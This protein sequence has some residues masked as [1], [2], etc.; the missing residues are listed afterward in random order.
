MELG[1]FTGLVRR[2]LTAAILLVSLATSSA[3]S[4]S[5]N[6]FEKL[7]GNW[8]GSGTVDPLKGNPER[9][10]CRATYKVEG[11]A[12]TQSMRC[13]GTEYK[14]DAHSNLT[15]EGGKISGA[16]NETRP[17][18]SRRRERHGERQFGARADQWRQ[19]LRPHEHQRVWLPAH[20]QHRAVRP[21][22]G[23]LSSGG[24]GVAAPLRILG[25][26]RSAMKRPLKALWRVRPA[27][28]PIATDPS[29]SSPQEP[30]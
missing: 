20:H 2:G 3:F 10:S 11:A 18:C 23:G 4:A 1:M 25:G 7:K 17:C 29:Q 24:L 6:P 15:Y 28:G 16:W 22:L 5:A 19:V 8:S 27:R 13:A 14:F 9:V 26:I 12:V 30:A 21:E